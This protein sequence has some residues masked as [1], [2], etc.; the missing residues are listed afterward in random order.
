MTG[1][2]HKH[3]VGRGG[4]GNVTD[5][6]S[7]SLSAADLQTPAISGS[8]YTTGRGGAG[9]MQHNTDANKARMAQDV[10]GYVDSP[11]TLI[12]LSRISAHSL[13]LPS[14]PPNKALEHSPE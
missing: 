1:G 8:T 7:P 5:E 3:T 2:P 4:A 13:P 12:P 14:F 10:V 11:S 9:N 6:Q